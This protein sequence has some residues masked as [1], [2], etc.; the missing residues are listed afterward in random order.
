MTMLNP[1]L[2]V[3]LAVGPVELVG[4]LMSRV[5]ARVG[6]T[7]PTSRALIATEADLSLVLPRKITQ[8]LRLKREERRRKLKKQSSNPL[9][10]A[11]QL[12][13]SISRSASR[14]SRQVSH[15]LSHATEFARH[16]LAKAKARGEGLSTTEGDS[17][18]GKRPVIADKNQ[19]AGILQRL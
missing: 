5:L 2:V 6:W 15:K 19:A 1:E 16:K 7:L 10:V 17:T 11:R 8:R 12:S 4:M 13:H 18:P 14:V 3:S 9:Q